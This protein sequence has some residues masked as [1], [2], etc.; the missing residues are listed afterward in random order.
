MFTTHEPKGSG[1]H[2]TIA[3]VHSSASSLQAEFPGVVHLPG[4][5]EYDALTTPWD[6]AV[7]QAPVAVAEPGDAAAVAAIVRAVVGLGLRIAPQTTGHAAAPLVHHQDLS[8]V[9]LLRTGRLTEVHIDAPRRLARIGGGAI[10]ADVIGAAA[11]H[12]LMVLHG[13]AADVGVV[14]YTLAGGLSFYGRRYGLAANSVRVIELVTAA[15]ELM[16]VDA[17]SDPELFWALRGGVGANFGI[18]TAVEMELFP[19]A[20]VHAGMM[21]WDI[22]HADPVLRTWAKWAKT[23]PEEVTTSLRI[24]RFPP[25]PELPPFL[26]GRRIVVIDGAVL[27]SSEDA[28]AVLAPLRAVAPEMDTFADM[29]TTVLTD[30]HMDPPEPTPS[31]AQGA[32]LDE[33]GEEGVRALLQEVG[34]SAECALTFLEL[35]QLGGAI[36]RS[37]EHGGAISALPGSFAMFACAIAPFPEAAAAG[38]AAG[39]SVR[40]AMTPWTNERSFPSFNHGESQVGTGYSAGDFARL[41]AVRER[42]DPDRVLAAHHPIY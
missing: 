21:L 40:R 16:R 41:R 28:A 7:R 38:Q 17:E 26:S 5:P 27:G 1:R 39:Q 15:G 25:L 31:V 34:P 23:A 6:L 4:G 18:V 36:G 42:V 19:L 3:S 9:V 33:L 11:E 10:W 30:V 22:G 29:P 20:T 8:D 13:S 14:G 35:R 12:G 32:I 2:M 24:M 37:P